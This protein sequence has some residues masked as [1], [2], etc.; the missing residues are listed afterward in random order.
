MCVYCWEEYGSPKILNADVLKAV[1]FIS[2][3]YEF[4]TVGGN[5]HVQLDDWNIDD[6]YWE[7]FSSF[8]D[9]ATEE[10][11]K[12]E[13]QCFETMGKLSVNERASALAL[14]NGYWPHGIYL[15]N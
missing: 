8:R 2:A 15:G 6:E 4:S 10:E 12:I 13:R 9:D 14:Y 5:L 3:I 11:L 1:S 7:Q